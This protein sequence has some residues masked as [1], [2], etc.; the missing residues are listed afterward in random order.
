MGLPHDDLVLPPGISYEDDRNQY[1]VRVRRKNRTVHQSR[2][3]VTDRG[4]EQAFRSL[5]DGK[6]KRQKIRKGEGSLGTSDADRAQA[7]ADGLF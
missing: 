7:L 3:A 5:R 2:H 1:R 4:L 6:L